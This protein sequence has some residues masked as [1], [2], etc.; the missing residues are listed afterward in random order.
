MI[1]TATGTSFSSS[2]LDSESWAVCLM[3][4]KAR[5]PRDAQMPMHV[6]TVNSTVVSMLRPGAEPNVVSDAADTEGSVA[7]AGAAAGSPASLDRTL[8]SLPPVPVNSQPKHA[9][10]L[11]AVHFF[12]KH[13]LQHSAMRC[14]SWQW[15]HGI[16]WQFQD[17]LAVCGCPAWHPSPRLQKNVPLFENVHGL[18]LVSL[19][20][21]PAAACAA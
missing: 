18:E 10:L 9:V 14:G 4:R 16:M 21:V 17:S 2:E 7:V 6:K 1:V 20:S 8:Y 12:S 5:M 13:P 19:R 11:A 15:L 3:A